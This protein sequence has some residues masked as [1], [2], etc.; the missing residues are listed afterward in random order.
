MALAH[1]IGDDVEAAYR[2]GDLFRKRRALAQAWCEFC[3][4]PP[5]AKPEPAS[6]TH[7][8]SFLRKVVGK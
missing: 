5:V 2:R 7:F 6:I 4:K 1:K 3:T 8:P